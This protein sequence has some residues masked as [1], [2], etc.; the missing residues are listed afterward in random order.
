M[1]ENMGVFLIIS[2]SSYRD[3]LQRVPVILSGTGIDNDIYITQTDGWNPGYAGSIHISV[4]NNGIKLSIL[5]VKL[6]KPSKL[7]YL[8]SD[9]TPISQNNA[10]I[11]WKVYL[12]PNGVANIRADFHI[13]SSYS[14]TDTVL[15]YGLC[16]SLYLDMDTNDNRMA[17]VVPLDGSYDPNDKAVLAPYGLAPGKPLEYKVRFQNTGDAAARRVVVVD[18]LSA[19]LDPETLHVL[20]SSHTMN[21][22]VRN[23][24]AQFIFDPIYLPDSNS[25][26]VLSQGFVRFQIQVKDK[27]TGPIYD[28]IHN[29]ASIYFDFNEPIL[30]NT[31]FIFAPL[32]VGTPFPTNKRV[33]FY[34]YPNPGYNQIHFHRLS[35]IENETIQV[36]SLTGASVLSFEI[37][38]GQKSVSLKLPENLM[39]GTYIIKSSTGSSQPWLYIHP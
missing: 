9:K 27:K 24:V 35:D 39:Q 1:L 29:R 7:T 34:V 31:A 6:S 38:A 2:D 37:L 14:N 26:A 15:L 4:R 30:T 36:Y 22:V 13:A 25:D 19:D 23:R 3:S 33:N 28:T 17:L 8:G 20:N 21:V 5:Y 18:T 32:F 10:N 16:D 12:N 11:V